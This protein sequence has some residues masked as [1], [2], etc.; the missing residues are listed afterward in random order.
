MFIF[1][2]LIQNGSLK[3]KKGRSFKVQ[4]YNMLKF[5]VQKSTVQLS[6]AVQKKESET[7]QN[8]FQSLAEITTAPI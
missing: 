1:H 4:W 7:S 6:T 8:Y 2:F 3:K 5:T